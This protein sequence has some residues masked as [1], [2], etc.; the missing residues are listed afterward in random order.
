MHSLQL[1]DWLFA[2]SWD[3]RWSWSTDYN[4]SNLL[5]DT[6][7]GDEPVMEGKKMRV[8]LL[9]AVVCSCAAGDEDSFNKRPCQ[10]NND[11]NAYSKFEVKHILPKKFKTSSTP[12]WEKHIKSLKRCKVAT[13]TFIERSK[14]NLV[15]KICNGDGW[16]RQG[17]LCTSN[18]KL[19]VYVVKVNISSCTV[20]NTPRKTEELVTVA[21]DKVGNQC[22]PVHLQAKQQTQKGRKV[23]CSPTADDDDYYWSDEQFNI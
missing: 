23:T 17:N 2:A 13:Q 8:V 21:C 22:L 14:V 18:S 5:H 4:V 3:P 9:I 10:P 12:V 11:Q 7:S 6:E 19:P 1:F 20:L 15:K 16:N